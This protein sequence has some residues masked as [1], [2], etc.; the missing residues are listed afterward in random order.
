MGKNINFEEKNTIR[1]DVKGK[2][3]IIEELLDPN[4]SNVIK[5]ANS[6][7]KRIKKG[8]RNINVCAKVKSGKRKIVEACSLNEVLDNKLGPEYEHIFT[9][10]LHKKAD[11]NQRTELENVGLSVISMNTK[12]NTKKLINIIKNHIQNQKKMIIH[13]D[14][15]D[16]GSK[17][18]QLMNLL[19]IEFVNNKDVHFVKY[20]AT[21]YD[22]L[23]EFLDEDI[24]KKIGKPSII[25][26]KPGKDYYGAKE[27]LRDGLFMEAKKTH[28]ISYDETKRHAIGIEF[29]DEFIQLVKELKDNHKNKKPC[30]G[31]LRVV[32]SRKFQ[33]ISNKSPSINI[34]DFNV[35]LQF[36][37]IIEENIGVKLIFGGGQKKDKVKEISWDDISEWEYGLP[38]IYIVNNTA[39][40]STEMKCHHLFAW[41][42]EYRKFD[43]AS[44]S[45]ITQSQERFVGHLSGVTHK[46]RIYGN[47][48]VAKFSAG[49]ITLDE[50][51]K[52]Q[53]NLSVNT[54]AKRYINNVLC[55]DFKKDNIEEA[56]NTY[57]NETRKHQKMVREYI[58]ENPDDISVKEYKKH[59]T[60]AQIKA[61]FKK[62]YNEC[63]G[64]KPN[65]KGMEN[66]KA[67]YKDENGNYHK[68]KNGYIKTSIRGLQD[69]RV[70]YKDELENHSGAISDISSIIP[71][72]IKLNACYENKESNS[73]D[74]ILMMRSYNGKKDITSSNK[75]CYNNHKI[76][77]DNDDILDDIPDNIKKI[78]NTNK[79]PKR[80]EFM[81]LNRYYKS[82]KSSN[83]HEYFNESSYVYK[84]YHE[85]ADHYNNKNKPNHKQ[86]IINSIKKNGEIIS[87]KRRQVIIADLGCGP[88]PIEKL[89]SF[90]DNF[91]FINVDHM[92]SNNPIIHK[93]DITD[94]KKL[95]G[96]T[97]ID[98][99]VMSLSMWG[100]ESNKNYYKYLEEVRRILKNDGVF[101]IVEPV[102]RWYSDSG[103]KLL[104]LL[105]TNN[106][107][108]TYQT[109]NK[110]EGD[111]F[112][113][114]KCRKLRN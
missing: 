98:I 108:V 112:M 50:L 73:K 87:N 110:E 40:R 27:Y 4:F 80:N 11:K 29:T 41:I 71:M 114:I 65:K 18:T 85:I 93:Y 74:F 51:L 72:F 38:K 47:V 14:E 107:E 44:I 75:S 31:F 102:E 100:N 105:K 32:G 82:M 22:A 55:Q 69:R 35:F 52:S 101:L 59:H 17:E 30:F 88:T 84:R 36:R 39:N 37:A 92:G 91:K 67:Q 8:R 60:D 15:L 66:Y 24:I 42:H 53:K 49:L 103:N 96:N 10:S 48:N 3:E 56:E 16:H 99:V 113:N 77:L 61:E 111:K 46:P 25:E 86:F 97:S 62:R 26:H 33:K 76:L 104:E 54:S 2:N 89:S 94:T 70:W 23:I 57:V 6:I 20:S 45:T 13:L 19:Y 81:E 95:I 1:N 12:P 109:G 58:E 63:I 21:P 79:M 7:I 90:P 28:K 9:S 78:I 34:L 64:V 5:T 83:L 43:R 68:D 106:F